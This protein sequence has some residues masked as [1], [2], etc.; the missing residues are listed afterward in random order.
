M[1]SE[2]IQPSSPSQEFCWKYFSPFHMIRFSLPIFCIITTSTETWF[3]TTYQWNRAGDLSLT[4]HA[5]FSQSHIS[6]ILSTGTSFRNHLYLFSPAAHL[7]FFINPHT[8]S[9]HSWK[10][11]LP[12]QDQKHLV[13]WEQFSML[14]SLGFSELNSVGLTF[15]LLKHI[16]L[17]LI[18]CYLGAL[19]SCLVP[20]LGVTSTER[21][22]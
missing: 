1:Y 14:N 18:L 20:F 21:A 11:L 17:F 22:A 16:Y 5:P 4:P 12:A 7:T 6:A 8:V 2:S 15:S 3:S 9:I 19:L 10:L 13:Y